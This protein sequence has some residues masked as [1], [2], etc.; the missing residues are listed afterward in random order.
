MSVQLLCENKG[1][2]SAENKG[3]KKLGHKLYHL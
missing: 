1:G 3:K 2:D